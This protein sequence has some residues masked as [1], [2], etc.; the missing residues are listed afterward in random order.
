MALPGAQEVIELLEP[1]TDEEAQ[2]G[3]DHPRPWLGPR[4]TQEWFWDMVNASGVK[5]ADRGWWS[6]NQHRYPRE[7]VPLGQMGYWERR[8]ASQQA[9]ADGIAHVRKAP[10]QPEDPLPPSKP[11]ADESLLIGT[12][13][14]QGLKVG[15]YVDGSGGLDL[16]LLDGTWQRQAWRF[17]EHEAYRRSKKKPAKRR[18][19]KLME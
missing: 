18:A 7:E 16:A 14:K 1:I 8:T 3:R 11:T 17:E 19:R 2:L 6:R 5:L 9:E 15:E 4:D 12:P 13:G 10:R